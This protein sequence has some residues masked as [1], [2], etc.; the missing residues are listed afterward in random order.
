[1]QGF[2][3]KICNK[4]CYYQKRFIVLKLTHDFEGKASTSITFGEEKA[5]IEILWSIE[6][7]RKFGKLVSP[8]TMYGFLSRWGFN[9][10]G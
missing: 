8:R 3:L 5:L 2:A 6:N 1:M 10:Q 7:L 9:V 4:Y